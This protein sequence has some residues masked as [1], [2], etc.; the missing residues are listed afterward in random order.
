MGAKWREEALEGIIEFQ[1]GLEPHYPN[2]I[3]LGVG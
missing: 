1:I 2:I 3:S